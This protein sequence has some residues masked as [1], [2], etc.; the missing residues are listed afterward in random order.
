LFSA[1]IVD[2]TERKQAEEE[3][4]R[5]RHLEGERLQASRTEMMGGLTASL[6]HELNQPL[7]AIQS[8]AEAARLFLAAQKPDLEQVKAA[9]D[10]VIQDNSRAA[11]TI[12]NIRALFQR[13]KVEMSPVD[14][15][16]IMY[17]V[18]RIVRTDAKLKNINVRLNLPT[19]LPSVIGNRTQLIEAL[20]NLLMNAFDSI[21]ESVES[22]REVKVSASEQEVGR[23][24][25]EVRDSGKGIESEI[26]P[27]L[28]DAFFTTKPRGMGMGL[29]IVRSIVENHGGRLWATRNPDRGATLGFDLPVIVSAL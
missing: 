26:V 12:R 20:M 15:R 19:S 10:D 27:R 23:V 21:C 29:A 8:N 5:I 25:I 16:E 24:H 17:D 11:E 18:E 6:A 22:A 28:F 7:A 14:L 13:D 9:I 2:I 3:L 4:K 1:V